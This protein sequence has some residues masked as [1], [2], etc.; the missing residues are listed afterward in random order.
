MRHLSS[1]T[2][3][4]GAY[5]NWE[6]LIDEELSVTRYL[7]AKLLAMVTAQQQ[8]KRPRVVQSKSNSEPLMR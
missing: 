1:I 5:Y 6:Q 4:S 3:R 2:F 7:P 8:M